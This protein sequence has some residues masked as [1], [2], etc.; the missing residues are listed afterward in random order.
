MLPEVRFAVLWPVRGWHEKAE[1]GLG[2]PQ[3][4]AMLTVLL[5][6]RGRQVSLDGLI[7]GLWGERVPQ[8]ARS[9]IRSYASRLRRCLDPGP[10]RQRGQ[11]IQ[12]AG[13]GYRLVAGTVC[14]GPQ[15]A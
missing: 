10:S 13:D 3:Q 6:A 12:S 15:A 14:C 11:L 5:L 1:L 8:A 9:T 4:R 2:S 7:D